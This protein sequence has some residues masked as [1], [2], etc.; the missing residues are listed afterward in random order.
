MKYLLA[1]TLFVCSCAAPMANLGGQQYQQDP[2]PQMAPMPT[3][4]PVPMPAPP[5]NCATSCYTRC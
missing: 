3:M 1:M 5:V 2:P 4:Q